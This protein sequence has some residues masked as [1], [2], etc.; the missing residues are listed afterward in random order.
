VCCITLK[1]YYYAFRRRVGKSCDDYLK[2]E[3][4]YNEIIFAYDGMNFEI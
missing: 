3:N 1:S 4:Q 2:L